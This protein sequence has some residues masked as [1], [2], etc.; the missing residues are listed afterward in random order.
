MNLKD[1]AYVLTCLKILTKEE[2]RMNEELL[3]ILKWARA[4]AWDLAIEDELYGSYITEAFPNE[5]SVKLT[6]TIRQVNVYKN[7]FGHNVLTLIANSREKSD[8]SKY[9]IRLYSPSM[10]TVKKLKELVDT[11]ITAVQAYCSIVN[12][13]TGETIIIA[14]SVKVSKNLDIQKSW[15][16]LKSDEELE[17]SPLLKDLKLDKKYVSIGELP[18]TL[19]IAETLSGPE[20]KKLW[21]P[22]L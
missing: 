15:A 4:Q 18:K 21:F 22:Y 17:Q 2:H 19:K 3:P 14:D 11:K 8:T 7:E 6:L 13:E 1:L 20:V 5:F 12:P 16:I 9:I 10:P